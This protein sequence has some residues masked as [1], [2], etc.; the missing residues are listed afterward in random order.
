MSLMSLPPP[1]HPPS[2]SSTPAS[3]PLG[4]FGSAPA[5]PPSAN[6]RAAEHPSTPSAI[7]EI[8]TAFVEKSL[9]RSACRC[10]DV[11]PP[12]AAADDGVDGDRRPRPP[13]DE[14]PEDERRALGI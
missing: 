3:H 6:L 2:S 12:A 9:C 8:L 4:K 1:R 7:L 5:S 14:R 11:G 10:C 13:A